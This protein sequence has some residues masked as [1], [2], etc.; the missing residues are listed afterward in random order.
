M[1]S[2][3]CWTLCTQTNTLVL[4]ASSQGFAH[5]KESTQ[6]Q[7][8]VH[9]HTI[10]AMQACCAYIW[11][12]CISH[13]IDYEHS[14][15]RHNTGFTCLSLRRVAQSQ[16]HNGTLIHF[17][18]FCCR[19]LTGFVFAQL[20][21]SQVAIPKLF[22]HFYWRAFSYTCFWISLF[23]FQEILIICCHLPGSRWVVLS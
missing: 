11:H 2:L 14:S 4:L 23:R 7:G 19:I 17:F 18:F 13:S 21:T 12:A 3:P 16:A 9:T 20:R 6:C 22:L 5:N 15:R 1:T 10:S 8:V